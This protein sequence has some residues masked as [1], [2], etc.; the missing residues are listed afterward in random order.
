MAL[1]SG[2][3]G[4]FIGRLSDRV[5]GK[6]LVMSGLLGMALGLAVIAL[7]AE[8]ELP[9]WQLIPGLLVCGLGMGLVLV[10]VN[11]V[12]MGTVPADL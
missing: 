12:A 10:P 9:P 4:P 11:N 6:Y 5:N 3:M 2:L 7:P 1:V 8:A